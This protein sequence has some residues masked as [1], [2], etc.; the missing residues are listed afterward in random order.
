VRRAI[1]Q[2][3]ES[4]K[5]LSRR[6]GMNPQTVAK[7]QQRTHGTDAPMGPTPPHATVLTTAQ[8]ALIVAC[9]QH[10]LRPLG[11]GLYALQAT[12]P[13][14]TRSA[15]HRCFT[16]HG[17]N[18]LPDR[19]SDTPAKKKF[20]PYPIGSFHMDMAE[21]RTAEGPHRLPGQYSAAIE[22]SPLHRRVASHWH[23]A[24]E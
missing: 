8:A 22:R 23:N 17:I 13:H 7:W 21:V 2:S 11:D 12:L 19:E 20:K 14:L 10:T 24:H 4:L 15:L 5:V 1:H 9:R 3:Q 16:R 6:E 18:R